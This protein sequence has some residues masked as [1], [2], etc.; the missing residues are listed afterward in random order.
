MQAW[1][2]NQT[3]PDQKRRMSS[4]SCQRLPDTTLTNY[5][6]ST[7]LPSHVWYAHSRT[8]TPPRGEPPPEPQGCQSKP[9]VSIPTR[10]TYVDTVPES[11][12]CALHHPKLNPSPLPPSCCSVRRL[13]KGRDA[14]AHAS[15][16]TKTIKQQASLA[17][18]LHIVSPSEIRD[19]TA[20]VAWHEHGMYWTV[21]AV[22][23]SV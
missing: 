9:P 10:E 21:R 20:H 5:Q 2:W 13:G 16:P 17:S 6:T 1:N 7:P 18:V 8:P 22:A 15:Q 4:M 3:K 19:M 23:V 11:P 12:T 14:P